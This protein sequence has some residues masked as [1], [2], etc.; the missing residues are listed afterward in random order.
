MEVA[1]VQADDTVCVFGAGAIG[2]MV[3][4][5]AVAVGATVILA[6]LSVDEE[7][8]GIA[9]EMGVQYTVDQQK[10]N[11]SELIAKITDDGV[12]HAFEC[13]GALQALHKAFEIVHKKAQVIQM[14]MYKEDMNLISM[15][16]LLHKEI[17]YMGSRSQKPSS[18][19]L[20]MDLFAK[21]N[22]HPEKAISMIVPVE[23]WKEAFESAP[24]GK[25]FVKFDDFG[26]KE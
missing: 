14:G 23:Q 26:E 13:A 1:K 12:D 19:A 9:K 6:G 4:Q 5:C 11:L 15:E 3:A 2:L 21:G 24:G 18:W 17:H 16:Y 22:I 10:E 20:A 7:R 25:K 8:F